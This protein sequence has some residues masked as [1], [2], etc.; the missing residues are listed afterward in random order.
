MNERIPS[1]EAKEC[2]PT[3]AFWWSAK[4][5]LQ[6]KPP[7]N[8]K[9][10]TKTPKSQSIAPLQKQTFLKLFRLRLCRLF[11]NPWHQKMQRLQCSGCFKAPMDVLRQS[12]EF[13]K[14]KKTKVKTN[15]KNAKKKT[16]NTSSQI[17]ILQAS[18]FHL[19]TVLILLFFV[20][21]KQHIGNSFSWPKTLG[22]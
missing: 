2:L 3:S 1:R 8:M 5:T 22:F 4:C 9:Q 16:N 18:N 17:S 12:L 19:S 15:A 14:G 11:G 20:G 6:T 7:E 10:Q 13:K 21:L